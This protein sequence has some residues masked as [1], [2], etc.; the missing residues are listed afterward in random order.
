MKVLFYYNAQNRLD[1]AIELI[2]RAHSKEKSTFIFSNSLSFLNDLNQK[3]WEKPLFLPHLFID[4]KDA[5]KTPF[6]LSDN[7]KKLTPEKPLIF[8]PF[9]PFDFVVED[10]TPFPF[11]YE[12]VDGDEENKKS[13]RLRTKEYKKQGFSVQYFDLMA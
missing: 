6:L 11:V 5:Q 3:L 12:I 4:E 7:L 8:I 9:P 2:L 13:A 1:S 10:L